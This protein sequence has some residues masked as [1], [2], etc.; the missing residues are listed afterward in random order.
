MILLFMTHLLISRFHTLYNDEPMHAVTVHYM[1]V[2]ID[3][4]DIIKRS[5]YIQSEVAI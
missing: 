4:G 2:R 3:T 5:L 1:S